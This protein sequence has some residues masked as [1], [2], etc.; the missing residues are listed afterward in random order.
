M[1][2]IAK[3]LCW[4]GVAKFGDQRLVIIGADESQTKQAMVIT[5][6]QYEAFGGSPSKIRELKDGQALCVQVRI[7]D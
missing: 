6:E 1:S 3:D 2:E 4:A 5:M 7:S